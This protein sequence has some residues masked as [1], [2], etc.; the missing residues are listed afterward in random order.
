MKMLALLY[1]EG[2]IPRCQKLF[3][4]LFLSQILCDAYIVP[5]LV[6]YT[7]L[8]LRVCSVWR[9]ELVFYVRRFFSQ[10]CHPWALHLNLMF[11]IFFH[12]PITL[13]LFLI[14]LLNSYWFLVLSLSNTT[15]KYEN[16]CVLTLILP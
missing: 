2:G 11:Q 3:L 1:Y 13:V 16:C 4:I 6:R 7:I 12:M 8:L 14:F 10:W 15:N 5:I 9:V